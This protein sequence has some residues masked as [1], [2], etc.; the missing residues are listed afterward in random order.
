M[1]E[2]I[3]YEV[4]TWGE[5]YKMTIELADKVKE[6]RFQPEIIVGVSRG[7]WTPAR[8]MSDLLDNPNLANVRVQFYEDIYRTSEE[9]QITQPVS[10]PVK[11]K[12]VLVVDDVA[13]TGKSL[14]LIREKLLEDGAA[15]VRIAT[16]FFKPWSITR[17]DFYVKTTDA[18]ICFSWEWYESVKKIGG[19]LRSEGKP[20][21]LIEEFLVS[22]GMEPFIVR[23]F[24]REIFKESP[25]AKGRT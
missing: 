8:V 3:T 17:P 5:L 1:P 24:V 10:V 13:D 14:K 6:S 7:G 18:W 9:P 11:G 23:K 16:I 19:K 12:R 21:P 25:P 22:I 2:E 20:L 4:P 15:E